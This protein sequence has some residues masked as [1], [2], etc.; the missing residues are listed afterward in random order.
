MH[1]MDTFDVDAM[2]A[3]PR[4]SGL[5][6]TP[7]GSRLVVTVGTLAPDGKSMRSAIWALD[8]TGEGHAHRLTRS[9]KGEASASFASD[10]SLLFVSARPDPDARS[11]DKDAT[12]S[13]LWHLPRD[14]GEARLLVAPFGGVDTARA[15]SR[16]TVIGFAAEIFAGGDLEA[17][18]ERH[19]AR[20][21]AGVSA[22]LFEG[23]PIRRWDR[24]L[25]PR[26]RHL[27]AIDMPEGPEAAILPPAAPRAGTGGAEGTDG[28]DGAGTAGH[29]GAAGDADADGPRADTGRRRSA[30]VESS[31]VLIPGVPAPRDLTPDAGTALVEMGFD[32]TPDGSTVVTGWVVEDD[33]TAIRSDLVAIDTRT[34]ERR[35]LVTD[36]ATYTD[37]AIS[38]DG[39]HAVVLRVSRATPDLA[40]VVT[41]HIVD[42]AT[43]D[44]RDLLPD[45]DL[46]PSPAA[47]TPDG[48]AIVF[49][50]DRWGSAAVFRLV[51][52]ADGSP[53]QP[54]LVADDAAFSDLAPTEHGLFALRSSYLEPPRPVS[55][56]QTGPVELPS[57]PELDAIELPARLERLTANAPDGHPVESWLVLPPD[58][59]AAS[60]APL[61]VWVHGGPVG[62]WNSWHWRWNPH[63]LVGRGYGVLLPDPAISTGYGQAFIQRGWG[64]WGAEPFTDVIAAVDGALE[65]DDL[66]RGRTALMGG[67]FGGYMANWVATRTDRFRAI[68][69]HASLWELRGFHG[70]TDYG[71]AM[72]DEF[73]DPYADPSR[74]DASNP[75]PE[76]G[77]IRTPMLVIHGELDHRVPISE[78]LRLWTDLRRHGVEAKFL[79]FPDENHW[80]LKPQNARLWYQTVLAFLDRYVLDRDWVR[81]A[82]L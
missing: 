47:W 23:Y 44:H 62:S 53:A 69:T 66:D 64:R 14:G 8:P 3:L 80:V 54:E 16:A 34:G 26:E 55:F 74:W 60:P 13:A 45:F 82:L 6:A 7:D 81:P 56:E 32:I 77:Q 57:V 38:P 30:D 68:V 19:E 37:P 29:A 79:Y 46:W 71:P 61:V 52:A 25:G 35:V 75:M 21:E 31:P 27:F 17:D 65:R 22:L 12:R 2:L 9:A 42:L 76:V 4:L 72:E 67:S 40:P 15:A 73:G 43:G 63:I 33:L 59:S 39:K 24:Y 20:R 28:A 58:A 50:A 10:G 51:I 49:T 41:L 36:D 48:R 11:D 1:T 5:R 78:A 18:R 70:T